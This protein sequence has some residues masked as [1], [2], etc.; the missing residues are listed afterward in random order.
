MNR[1]II[2]ISYYICLDSYLV[3]FVLVVS[4]V[5]ALF[6]C[7]SLSPVTYFFLERNEIKSQATF[8]LTIFFINIVLVDY[9]V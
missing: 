9:L 4:F 1:V 6:I 2:F 8:S 5:S 7:D 3:L